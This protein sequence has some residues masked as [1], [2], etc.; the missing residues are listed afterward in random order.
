MAKADRS[1]RCTAGCRS[2]WSSCRCAR[3]GKITGS[4]RPCRP[5]DQPGAD[6]AGRGGAGAAPAPRRA[7]A[8]F[9]FEP[10]GHSG[11]ALRHALTSLPHDLLDQS[12]HRSGHA[13]WWSPPC[14]SPT[15][16]GRPWRW[17]ARS[18]RAICSPSSGCRATSSPPRRRVAIGEM[19]ARGRRRAADQLV[20]RPRRR[21]P[22]AASATP[23]D[24]FQARRRPT[25]AALDRKL[26]AMV[27]G[28]APASRSALGRAGRRPARAARLAL[29][30][31]TGFPERLSLALPDRRRGR[32]TSSASTAS[33]TTGERDG[34]ALPAATIDPESQLRLKIYRMGGARPAVRRGAGAR[35]FRLPRA[36]GDADPARRARASGYIHEFDVQHC[37]RSAPPTRC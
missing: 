21:R 2:T 27:R 32:T 29:T 5:V 22:R 35:E 4:R 34:P 8:E 37:R 31:A 10:Q 26:D 13:S 25:S 24:R 12:R 1:R 20:G 6:R 16:R 3:Q 23:N 30:Y 9:G 33:T 18:S 28:W 14:R 36:Q 17:S 15:G 11:K 19:I 7:G